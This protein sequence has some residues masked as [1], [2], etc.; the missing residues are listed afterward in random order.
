MTEVECMTAAK[1]GLPV[2]HSIAATHDAIEYECISALILIPDGKGGLNM[3]VEL[4]SKTGNSITRARPEDI[5]SRENWKNEKF[6]SNNY[7]TTRTDSSAVYWKSSMY[8]KGRA[9]GI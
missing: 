6:N 7:C 1:M 2:V 8:A 3:S 5:K 9:C 4:K